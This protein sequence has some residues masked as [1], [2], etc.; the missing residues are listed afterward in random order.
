MQALG[1]T[2]VAALILFVADQLL[3][4]GRYSDVAADI[5]RHT[6]GLVGIHI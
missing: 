3:N 2:A 5:L 6:C 1:G 4:A